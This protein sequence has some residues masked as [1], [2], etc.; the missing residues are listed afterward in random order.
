MAVLIQEGFSYP[1][2]G[3]GLVENGGLVSKA[4]VGAWEDLYLNGRVQRPLDGLWGWVVQTGEPV[5][6]PDL[7][8][9]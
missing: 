5:L 6:V 1:H 4:Q 2:V 8:G 3:I 9:L 7:R